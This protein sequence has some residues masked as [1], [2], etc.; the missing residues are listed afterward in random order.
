VGRS[1]EISQL[2]EFHGQRKHVLILGPVGVGKSALVLHL[3]AQLRLL[4]SLKSEHLGEICDNLEPELHLVSAGTKLLKRKQRLRQAL[5]ETGRT[6]VFDGAGWTTP[7][8]SSFLETVAERVPVWICARSD[9]PWDIGRIWPFLVRFARVE[10]HPFH[11]AETRALIQASVLA[12]I[13]PAEVRNIAEWLHRRS[14]G[15]PLVLRELFDE[16][17][18]GKYDLANPYA[19][20][21]LD[22]DRRIHEIFPSSNPIADGPKGKA[23]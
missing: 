5:G 13:I 23:L 8:L 19:L 6:V 21:R 11:P 16:L 22:L 14:A 18:T 10:L 17:A 12:G 9:H 7:K 1:R 3:R 4:V 15:S 2:H 20:R